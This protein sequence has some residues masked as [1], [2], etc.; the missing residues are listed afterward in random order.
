MWQTTLLY[1]RRFCVNY[2][3]FRHCHMHKGVYVTILWQ[4]IYLSLHY[5]QIT[6]ESHGKVCFCV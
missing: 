6:L 1:N 4:F 2:S 5:L 3:T